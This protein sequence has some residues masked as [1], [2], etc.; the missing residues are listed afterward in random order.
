MKS[1]TS[2]LVIEA[3]LVL[4]FFAVAGAILIVGQYLYIAG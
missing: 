1:A 2:C 4:G 3:V